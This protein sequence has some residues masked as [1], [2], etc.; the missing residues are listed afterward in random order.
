MSR[1]G[2][3]KPREVIPD[4][5]YKS[6]TVAKLIRRFMRH[7]KIRVA[8]KIVYGAL[9][10][11]SSKYKMEDPVS[12]LEEALKNLSPSV[13]TRPRRVGGAIQQVPT[14]VGPHRASILAMQWL[15]DVTRARTEKGTSNKLAAEIVDAYR[16]TGA[17]IKKKEDNQKM[18]KS[19]NVFASV[20]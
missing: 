7:G 1:G 11:V 12:V 13:I 14:E 6:K 10:L 20:I 5:V 3:R 9:D 15:R 4:I 16:K 8:S 17:S 2:A 19:N 18:A